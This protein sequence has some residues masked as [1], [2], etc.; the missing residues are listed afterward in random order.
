MKTEIDVEKLTK[1]ARLKLTDEEKERL[2]GELSDIVEFY[3]MLAGVG[4]NAPDA[5]PVLFNVLRDDGTKPCLG[6]GELLAN[7][8]DSADGCFRVPRVVPEEQ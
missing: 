6:R 5:G 8:P 1:L 3:D 4:E 7:S 2:C